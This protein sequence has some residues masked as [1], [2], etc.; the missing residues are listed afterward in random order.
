[1]EINFMESKYLKE[2]EYLYFFFSGHTKFHLFPCSGEVL[3]TTT[4]G[5]Q[6]DAERAVQSSRKAFKS[7][8]ALSSHVRARY[9][10][11][12]VFAIISTAYFS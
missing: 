6:E 10:Y 4:Q 2:H 12:S 9:L 8:S 5:E 11:R 1:M 7:W 3:A